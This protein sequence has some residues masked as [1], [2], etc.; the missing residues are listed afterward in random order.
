MHLS[1][2]RELVADQTLFSPHEKRSIAVEK[3]RISAAEKKLG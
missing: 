2:R 1:H 3:R